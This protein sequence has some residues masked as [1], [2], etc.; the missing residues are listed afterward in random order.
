M[1]WNEGRLLTFI[2]SLRSLI[3]LALYWSVL[4]F[5]A[6]SPLLPL[7]G[8]VLLATQFSADP[9]NA[10]YAAEGNK[11]TSALRCATGN[12]KSIGWKPVTFPLLTPR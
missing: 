3:G 7:R 9:A 12:A 4:C 6:L 5:P 1:L 10:R 11:S 2:F 8:L